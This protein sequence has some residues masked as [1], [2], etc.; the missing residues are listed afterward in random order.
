MRQ[1]QRERDD[2]DDRAPDHRLAADPV[3]DRAADQGP[4]RDRRQQ[5]DVRGRRHESGRQR[6]PSPLEG[7]ADV[8]PH[9][10]TH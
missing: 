5:D 6:Q 9:T 4:D 3:A 8:V 10:Q 2:A 1:G 7:R